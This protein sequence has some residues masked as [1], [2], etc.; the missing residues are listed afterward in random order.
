MQ[1]ISFNSG[2]ILFNSATVPGLSPNTSISLPPGGR[3]GKV[4]V[5]GLLFH[6]NPFIWV[7]KG[8]ENYNRPLTRTSGGRIEWLMKANQNPH[9]PIQSSFT[10]TRLIPVMMDFVNS[11][12]D[13]GK[14]SSGKD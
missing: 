14:L 5:S 10:I 13:F 7:G 1:F 3:G 6:G 4:S 11:N 2:P 8:K 12:P 9:A